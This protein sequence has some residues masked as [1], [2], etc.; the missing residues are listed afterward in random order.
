MSHKPILM[1]GI[2]LL[3]Y[4]QGKSLQCHYRLAPSTT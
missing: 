1:I 4:S 2:I 3:P